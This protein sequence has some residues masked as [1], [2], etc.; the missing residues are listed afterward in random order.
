MENLDLARFYQ[1]KVLSASSVNE[2]VEFLLQ[3][4]RYAIIAIIFSAFTLEAYIN[5][6]AARKG[7]EK[8][9]KGL[10]FV[11]KWVEI[12]KLA[13]GKEFP[14]DSKCFSF[15]EELKKSRNELVHSKS[16]TLELENQGDVKR[17]G[18]DAYSLVA[19]AEKAVE[20][21]FAVVKCLTEIDPEEKR[22]LLGLTTELSRK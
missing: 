1:Q 18:D 3:S 22:Y 10:G 16:K 13:T 17:I 8:H 6:Y 20:T 12:P 2:H 9:L 5:N 14:K 19:S 7:L 15:L 21:I 4:K 11:N